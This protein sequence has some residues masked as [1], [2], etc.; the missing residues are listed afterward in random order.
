MVPVTTIAASGASQAL[1]AAAAG[2]RA[3]DITLTANCALSLS[4]GVAGQQQAI[5]VYLRQSG[6]GGFQPAL[7]PGVRWPGGTAPTPNSAA[8]VIDVFRFAT[9]DAGAT[10]FGSY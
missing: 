7:P 2:D 6:A 3:F 8:G 4:G 9:P 10:W 5:T 1:A